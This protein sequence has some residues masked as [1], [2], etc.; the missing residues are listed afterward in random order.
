M[1]DRNLVNIPTP[2]KIILKSLPHIIHSIIIHLDTDSGSDNIN[3]YETVIL[4]TPSSEDT[5][6]LLAQPIQ[7][8]V[9][10]SFAQKQVQYWD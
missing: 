6:Q 8:K 3:K 2:Q 1:T 10:K 4:R 9:I 5:Y 7:C